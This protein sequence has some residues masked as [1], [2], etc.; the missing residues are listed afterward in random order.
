MVVNTSNTWLAALAVAAAGA[1]GAAELEQSVVV[2]ATRH[3]MLETAAPAAMSV[4]TRRQ[5]E[6][7]GADNLLEALRGEA[8]VSL[9]GRAIGGR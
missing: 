9:Q 3:A 8:G 5:I 7:R 6:D 1:A 4:V 2:T